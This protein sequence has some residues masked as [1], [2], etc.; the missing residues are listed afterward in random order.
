MIKNVGWATCCPPIS[1]DLTMVGNKL[2]TLRNV[3]HGEHQ[4][5]PNGAINELF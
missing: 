2:P 5:P 1:L 4:C 3:P